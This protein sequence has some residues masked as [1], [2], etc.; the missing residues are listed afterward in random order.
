MYK[1]CPTLTRLDNFG[2]ESPSSARFAR[3]PCLRH[4][5]I[6]NWCVTSWSCPLTSAGVRSTSRVHFAAPSLDQWSKNIYC[7]AFLGKSFFTS[8]GG[9]EPQNPRTGN[10]L[11][12]DGP[13]SIFQ[14]RAKN[15]FFPIF[16]LSWVHLSFSRQSLLDMPFLPDRPT[17]SYSTAYRQTKSPRRACWSID[18]TA[19]GCAWWLYLLLDD[20]Y[21]DW[22]H[23]VGRLP[24]RKCRSVGVST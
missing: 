24:C 18:Q 1:Y 23:E 15:L 11:D 20:K 9:W 21:S 8:G 7:L 22:K 6:S 13:I 3:S 19:G 10:L 14:I 4:F 12:Q 16:F 5:S 17:K 2:Q